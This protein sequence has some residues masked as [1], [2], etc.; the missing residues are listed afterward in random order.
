MERVCGESKTKV[1]TSKLEK[2]FVGEGLKGSNISISPWMSFKDLTSHLEST[3]WITVGVICNG[4]AKIQVNSRAYTMRPNSIFLLG[5]DSVVE[6]FK[7]SKA[8][9]GYMIRFSSSA[10]EALNLETSD[11]MS[12]NMA[13]NKNPIVEVDSNIITGLHC[14]A[15]QMLFTSRQE[16]NTYRYRAVESLASAL[17]YNFASIIISNHK[18]MSEFKLKSS[19]SDEIFR[20]FLRMVSEK[21]CEYRFVEYYAE[22]LGITAKYLSLVCK[23]QSGKNASK[24]IDDAV[25]HKAKEL[26]GQHG[27]SVNEIALKMNFVSQSFFGKYFKQRVGVSPSRYRGS[28]L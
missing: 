2:Y 16:S 4:S 3:E 18:R 12:I 26:L 25:I 13:I 6:D 11:L 19:R 10:F 27:L 7:C 8:C 1:N 28:K 17:F 22:A 21:C 20:H 15:A 14:V 23:R 5:K 9:E 24:I